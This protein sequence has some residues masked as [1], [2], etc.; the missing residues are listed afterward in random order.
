L[1]DRIDVV[2]GKALFGLKKLDAVAGF[3][4]AAGE[5]C[6]NENCAKQREANERQR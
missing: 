3:E 4:R 1:D 6:G 2:F 5:C